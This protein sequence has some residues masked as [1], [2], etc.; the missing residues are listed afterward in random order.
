MDSRSHRMI[1][2]G[3]PMRPARARSILRRKR[4]RI[5]Y[6]RFLVS[7]GVRRRNPTRPSP[8][9]RREIRHDQDQN[10][11]SSNRSPLTLSL[12][13]AGQTMV[14]SPGAPV[15]PRVGQSQSQSPVESSVIVVKSE[16]TDE[17]LA[18]LYMARKDYREAALSYKRL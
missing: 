18:D 7:L 2:T 4:K 10:G 13:S 12:T 1:P 5:L 14:E 9:R 15:A 3:R 11:V 16:L 8:S 6:R 17:Q